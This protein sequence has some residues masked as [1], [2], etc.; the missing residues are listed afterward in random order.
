M[1]FYVISCHHPRDPLIRL[2]VRVSRAAPR[3]RRAL[4]GPDQTPTNITNN[5]HVLPLSGTLAP[6]GA[7]API[8]YPTRIQCERIEIEGQK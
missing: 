5:A 8:A 7:P 3:A 1:L 4:S 2:A 6:S